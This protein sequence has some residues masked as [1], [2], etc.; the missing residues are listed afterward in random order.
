MKYEGFTVPLSPFRTTAFIEEKPVPKKGNPLK[1]KA[2]GPGLSGGKIN[3]PCEFSIDTREAG[4]GGLGL[5]IEGP[6]EAKID[7]FDKGNGTCDVKYWPTE[8]GDYL[9]N[10][11][12]DEAPIVSSPFKAKITPNV[13]VSSIRV[14]G[15][16][17]QP[18]GLNFT[19]LVVVMLRRL[20][21]MKTDIIVKK[22]L[23][24]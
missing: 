12:Y 18:T 16:G 24:F 23:F 14:Y 6:C 1:V 8:P 22:E 5:A 2:Y 17:L 9:V 7:C 10:I 13:D 4:P 15:P 19:H 21:R 11:S 3:T 20:V